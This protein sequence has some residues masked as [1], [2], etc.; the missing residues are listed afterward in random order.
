MLDWLGKSNSAKHDDRFF[1]SNFALVDLRSQGDIHLTRS[2]SAMALKASVT[3]NEELLAT[4]SVKS[5]RQEQFAAA[6]G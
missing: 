3:W 4:I 5:E 2:R 6:L 1:V